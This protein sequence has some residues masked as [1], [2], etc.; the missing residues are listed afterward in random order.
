M[1]PKAKH[2]KISL[3]RKEPKWKVENMAALSPFFQR[4]AGESF[5]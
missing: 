1:K 5:S 2:V 3:Q 4:K